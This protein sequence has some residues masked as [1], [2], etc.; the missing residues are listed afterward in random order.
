M[1]VKVNRA[2]APIKSVSLTT[3]LMSEL[4]A[5]DRGNVSLGCTKPGC[6]DHDGE[7]YN[8]HVV[9]NDLAEWCRAV[10]EMLDQ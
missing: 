8:A 3:K 7:P 4:L 6:E 5:D 1:A 2:D 9:P 10:L